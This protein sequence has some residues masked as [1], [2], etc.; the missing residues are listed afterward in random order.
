MLI[1]SIKQNA[2]DLILSIRPVLPILRCLRRESRLSQDF[3]VV[4][5]SFQMMGAATEKCG[6]TMA[7]LSQKQ[8]KVNNMSVLD[9][10]IICA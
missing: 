1:R 3:N 7:A 2:M 8:A 6:S 5:S 4:G 9:T 10:E